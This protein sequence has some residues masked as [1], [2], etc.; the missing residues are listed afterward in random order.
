MKRVLV[1]GAGGFIGRQTLAPLRAAGCEI[2]AASLTVPDDAPSGIQWY[3][4][5]L[6]NG[7]EID[8]LLQTVRPTHLLH[9]AWYA[10]PGKFWNAPENRDWLEAG[11]VL[12][13][14]FC[15]HGGQR[16]VFA[17]TCAEYETGH[18]QCVENQTPLRPATLYGVCKNELHQFVSQQSALSAAWGRVFHLYGLNEYPQRFVPAVICA[19]L[20]GEE[21]RCTAGTQLRDF[22]NV[23]DVADAFVKLLLSPVE[24]AVNIASGRPV[25]LADIARTVAKKL[26]AEER[27][28]LGALPVP[29]SEPSVLTACVERLSREVNWTQSVSLEQ[30]LDEA[31]AWWRENL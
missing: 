27:L 21:A 10:E 4:H 3:K 25:Q 19:L 31:I 7:P 12:L 11:K 8:E 28:R 14:T 26:D 29:D 20:R 5:N 6:L 1:T 18:G 2:H 17:G 16:A 23:R 24:G 9:M 15:D 22:M 30:G 13:K